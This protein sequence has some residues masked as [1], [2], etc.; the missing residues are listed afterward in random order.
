MQVLFLAWILSS[1]PAWGA[2]QEYRIAAAPA[3]SD[4][5]PAVAYRLPYSL[6]THEGQARTI[7]GSITV[8]LT[9][10]AQAN[11]SFRLPLRALVSDNTERDCH[12]LEAMG[13]DY[14]P[15]DFPEEHVCDDGDQLPKSGKNSVQYPDIELKIASIRSMDPSGAIASDRET[16]LEVSGTWSMHGMQRPARVA[17][18]AT[19][20]NGGKFR[21]RGT[22]KISLKDHG[23][24]VKSAKILFVTI[25]V[26]NEAT[27]AIDLWLE[28]KK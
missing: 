21:L 15:S 22:T 12:M 10:P 11:G 17:L 18:T 14:G 26:D 28:P 9:Q 2:P 5:P 6:G 4:A 7:T 24:Q 25:S 3:A 19:P 23:I 20:E 1:L 16:S 13:L 8:D 27:V